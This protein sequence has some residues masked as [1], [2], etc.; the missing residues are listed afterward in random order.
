MTDIQSAYLGTASR[1]DVFKAVG[2]MGLTRDEKAPVK[3]TQDQKAEVLQN[4]EIKALKEQ[5]K[6][7]ERYLED[8]TIEGP[9]FSAEYRTLK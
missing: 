4:S 3:L 7:K 2:R 5:I 8:H 1:D 9:S 6:I